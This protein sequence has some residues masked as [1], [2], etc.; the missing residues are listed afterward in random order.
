MWDSLA[1]LLKIMQQ[2]KAG[3]YDEKEVG[4]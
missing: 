2:R 3:D 4:F 1:D